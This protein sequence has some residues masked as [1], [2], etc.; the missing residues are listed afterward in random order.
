MAMTACT[1][2]APPTAPTVQVLPPPGKDDRAFQEEGAQCRQR[3][4]ASLNLPPHIAIRENAAMAAARLGTNV[5]P[6]GLPTGSWA[7]LSPQ[8]R[9]DT[10]YLL[11]MGT[12]GNGP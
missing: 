11:C 3:A 9:Y 10:T 5:A 12:F 1:A 4:A 6:A 8:A 7:S 2:A